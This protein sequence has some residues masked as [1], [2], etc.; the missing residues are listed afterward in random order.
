MLSLAQAALGLPPP[1]YLHLSLG[2][3]GPGGYACSGPY[4]HIDCLPFLTPEILPIVTGG[5]GDSRARAHVNASAATRNCICMWGG[6][7]RST[8]KGPRSSLA[9]GPFAAFDAA[10][11]E[12]KNG[13][14]DGNLQKR[15]ARY[16]SQGR[17]ARKRVGR[18]VSP[19]IRATIRV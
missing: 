14:A 7:S 9:W 1:L 5:G 6:L 4:L 17:S 8:C 10:S 12:A 16:H 3:K 15:L 2:R 11:Q 13:S 19:G 18:V